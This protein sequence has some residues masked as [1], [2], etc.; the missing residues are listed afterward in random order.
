MLDPKNLFVLDYSNQQKAWHVD[1]LENVFRFN[2][3]W[4]VKGEV[5]NDYKILVISDSRD[6]LR[7]F[8]K[9]IRKQIENS[10]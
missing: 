7:D 2:L 5:G 10:E 4:F 8:K 1:S 9:V 6:E 3:G